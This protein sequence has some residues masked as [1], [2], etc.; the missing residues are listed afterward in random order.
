MSSHKRI[1]VT[2]SSG[3]LGRH[4][5]EHLKDVDG[6]E[7]YALS[8]HPMELKE[9]IQG[10][11][12]IYLHKSAVTGNEAAEIMGKAIVVN[13]AYPRNST[14]IAV[15]DGLIYIKN[16]FESAVAN[17]AAGIINISSQS[18][19]SQ[20]RTEPA[21]EETPACLESPYAIGKY[22][23]ELMLDSIGKNSSSRY[24]SLRMASLIGPGFDQRIVNRFV[25]QALETGK[26]TVKNNRQQFGFFDVEDAT[27]GIIGMLGSSVQDWKPVYNLGGEKTYTLSDIAVTVKNQTEKTINQQIEIEIVDGDEM[28]NSGM[29]CS[30][31]YK[32]F[33]FCPQR[34]LSDSV[35]RI[36][37]ELLNQR[38]NQPH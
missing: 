9:M 18:V 4:L 37:L 33:G 20:Q 31:F 23:V 32:E 2:G 38:N 3:F 16:T 6:Y 28:S 29:D 15:A 34:S 25:K 26:L 21:T 17:N 19:Y 8:S 10:N 7:V 14:G 24:S 5:I 1:V 11:N 22:A 13:C 12:I 30:L 36:L 35:R 27:D